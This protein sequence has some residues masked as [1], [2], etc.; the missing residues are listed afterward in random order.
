MAEHPTIK[1]VPIGGLDVDSED[2]KIAPSDYRF[3]ETMRNSV[4]YTGQQIVPC[5]MKGNELVAFYFSAARLACIGSLEDKG[6]NT[7][8]Y[9]IWSSDGLHKILRY[10]P[11]RTDAN[12]LGHIETIIEFDFGWYEDF[13][14]TG[15]DFIDNKLLYWVDNVKPRMIN[16]D[17]ANLTNK[18]KSWEVILPICE[19]VSETI[20]VDF[21]TLTHI[22]GSLPYET[23]ISIGN[24]DTLNSAIADKIR[25]LQ[26]GDVF[27]ISGAN[28]ASNNKLF[29]VVTVQ[30]L[31]TS[32]LIMVQE[33][34]ID[35]TTTIQLT[36]GPPLIDNFLIT[37]NSMNAIVRAS[38][39]AITPETGKLEYITNLINT[40]LSEYFSAEFCECKIIITEKFVNS[41]YPVF[42]DV[43]YKV[44]ALNY[45]GLELSDRYFDA[46]K[47]PPACEPKVEYKK[48]PS[49]NYNYVRDKVLFFRL[50]YEYDNYEQSAL[51]PISQ[52]AVNN[53]VCNSLAYDAF[54]YIDVD[55]N[56]PELLDPATWVILKKIG[57]YVKEHNSGTWK[58]VGSSLEMCEVLE[59]VSCSR[60]GEIYAHFDFYNNINTTAVAEQ[61][62]NKPYDN[63]PQKA[64]A[65][66]FA[67]D[68]ITYAG[69]VEGLNGPDCVEAE[70]EVNFEDHA[71][72]EYVNIS[73]IIRIC[74]NSGDGVKTTAG[75]NK[76]GYQVG[77]SSFLDNGIINILNRRGAILRH[78]DD[79]QYNAYPVFGGAF[80][81]G[82]SLN[83]NGWNQV[84]PEGGFLV[85]LAGTPY[86]GISR[87]VTQ[88]GLA[89]DEFGALQT[90]AS[91][92]NVPAI[93][94]FL[95]LGTAPNSEIYQ[96]VTI[97]APKGKYIVRVASP[98]CS[99]GDVLGKGKV[100]DIN[101]G[102]YQLTS[103]NVFRINDANGAQIGTT[104]LAIDV[105]QDT[106]FGEIY[107][108]DTMGRN[109]GTDIFRSVYGYL[110]DAT[111]FNQQGQEVKAV[112]IENQTVILSDDGWDF[113][114]QDSF[115]N[116]SGSTILLR[117]AT[118]TD[119]NGY[120]FFL[121]PVTDSIV[122]AYITVIGCDSQGISNF[123]QVK[124][125]GSI[126]V[127]YDNI[128][129]YATQQSSRT[130][131]T[132]LAPEGWPPN[133]QANILGQ[134]V[135]QQTSG[136][137][138]ITQISRE[139]IIVNE[140]STY[141]TD[142]ATVING[143]F[144]DSEG[145]GICCLNAVYTRNGRPA[146]SDDSGRFYILAFADGR[147]A[148]QLSG[149]ANHAWSPIAISSMTGPLAQSNIARIYF[150]SGDEC[151]ADISI[152]EMQLP[153]T[154]YGPNLTAIPTP[155][156]IT[157]WY[158]I[159]DIICTLLNGD[160][161]KSAK[162]GTEYELVL[163]Y[164][165]PAGRYCGPVRA[166]KI[167]TP[168]LTEDLNKYFPTRFPAGTFSMGYPV[169]S[170]S[171]PASFKPPKW[172]SHYQFLRTKKIN[173][174]YFLQWLINDVKYVMQGSET[175]DPITTVYSNFNATQ[176]WL[177]IDNILQYAQEHP[178][179]Q[180]KYQFIEGQRIRFIA[181]ENGTGFQTYI[182]LE[183][184]GIK[185]NNWLKLNFFRDL[186]EIKTGMRVE[187]YNPKLD[188][189]ENIYYE[190]G[191]CFECTAP[192][193]DNNEHSVTAGTFTW[194][195]TYWVRRNFPINDTT[196]I[197]IK[198]NILFIV[199]SSGI[200]DFYPSTDEDLG[201]IGII[202]D[203]LRQVYRNAFRVSDTYLSDTGINGLSSFNNI[204]DK[205][206]GREFGDIMKLVISGF[207]LGAVCKNKFVS[208]YLGAVQGVTPTGGMTISSQDGYIGDSRPLLGDFGT[209]HPATIYEM[210][211]WSW[212]V[213][214]DKGVAWKYDNNGIDILSDPKRKMMNYFRALSKSDIWDAVAGF[215]RFYGEYILTTW[216]ARREQVELI[217]YGTNGSMILSTP[218]TSSY[219]VGEVLELSFTNTR[220]GQAITIRATVTLITAPYLFIQMRVSDEVTF[221]DL[222]PST[223]VLIRAKGEGDTVA[224]QKD[225]QRWTVHYP[226]RPESMCPIG[227]DFVSW[228]NGGLYVHDEG[229]INTFY[230]VYAKWKLTTVANGG[231]ENN[232][233]KLWM[234]IFLEQKQNARN[235]VSNWSIPVVKNEIGQLSRIVKGA[236][237]RLEEYWH[238]WFRGDMNTLSVADP[239]LDGK[240]LR[241]STIVLEM[242][243]DATEAVELRAIDV[244]YF[245]SSGNLK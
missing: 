148:I 19:C 240:D 121:V 64:N 112:G 229:A 78:N 35:E 32:T 34:L 181:D 160:F 191:E 210:D 219:T 171:L 14:I 97:R 211:G 215:D 135:R 196:D 33:S 165:D 89:V 207:V 105:T 58:K 183:I 96:E 140:N 4:T 110:V 145:A 93:Q 11:K 6:Q 44:V 92:A 132:Y 46:C 62:S 55:F 60:P 5:N 233:V 237:N 125:I 169:I 81:D 224:Y 51:G 203:K 13:R 153:I 100:Y 208:N 209:Q 193:E 138:D 94:A 48:D 152:D 39:Q 119:H 218:N 61:L 113:G 226:F 243:N 223:T 180:I 216:K 241:S 118:Y 66:K 128:W 20:T 204:D 10:Y 87:Q 53:Q 222:V 133:V 77:Y 231:E 84:I 31:S 141:K 30:N 146:K 228:N 136:A 117:S 108:A 71:Q 80:Y 235:T 24:L 205:A 50:G 244:Q 25:G 179:S 47:Y 202:N 154:P 170:W 164:Q 67:K 195:D 90:G 187:I 40:N 42:T 192:G 155:Y 220:T 37:A 106:Y 194:G 161:I 115:S 227:T 236:F 150:S 172:A 245:D 238:A 200:N 190:C 127:L 68:K 101:N 185:D 213:D 103:T 91:Q 43:N 158:T 69:V 98:Q 126:G 52:I 72:N 212:G 225:K 142:F 217:K 99:Y 36:F 159:A 56:D 163:R 3:A 104:E 176:I 70:F 1:L 144:I 139:V 234:S 198:K 230:G 242:E 8:L 239:L 85:Y 38:T 82:V 122:S 65:Q 173:S 130:P 107:I 49:V 157:A 162:R 79:G 102:L 143:R 86:Y 26:Q 188:T 16:V 45:Y 124:Y 174:S 7:I 22:S 134:Q 109:N 151:M 131:T 199:E 166:G 57:L 206:L 147:H 123:N 2:A 184:V 59:C 18:L 95:G 54:N 21:A 23:F 232:R 63:L 120:F 9:F 15:I 75:V 129:L 28:N 177:N 41:Y 149:P 27:T 137:V 73:F 167:Y 12:P 111:M 156:S 197:V 114:N 29:T 201:R 168:F 116:D 186:G 214:L 178:S 74:M 17:K 76:I 182:D 221:A 189:A 83:Q 88:S 175:G